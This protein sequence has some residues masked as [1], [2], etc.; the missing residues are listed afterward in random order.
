[1]SFKNIVYSE[2]NL[3]RALHKTVPTEKGIHHFKADDSLL[4]F[5]NSV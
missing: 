2:A 5:L 4:S 3:E 1:M